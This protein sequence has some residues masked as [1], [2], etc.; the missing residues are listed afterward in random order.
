METCEV[1]S[2]ADL[3]Q[4]L[5]GPKATGEFLGATPQKV[6]NWRADDR[7]P[8]RFY[9]THKQKLAAKRISAPASLWGMAEPE[10]AA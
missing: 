5:G 10:R 9:L 3:V 1:S 7:L 6:V 4:L 2:V 8:A